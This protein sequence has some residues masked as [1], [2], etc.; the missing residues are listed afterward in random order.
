MNS[1]L[2]KPI[3]E[4]GVIAD[5]DGPEAKDVEEQDKRRAVGPVGY[6]SFSL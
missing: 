3:R 1:L 6:F 2:E 4:E 5:R